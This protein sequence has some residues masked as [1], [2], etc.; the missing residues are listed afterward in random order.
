MF[1]DWNA[2]GTAS[3]FQVIPSNERGECNWF[4]PQQIH[5]GGMNILLMDGSVRSVSSSINVASW[6]AALTPSGGETIPLD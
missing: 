5:T 2:R 1:N 4:L 3:K 6:A